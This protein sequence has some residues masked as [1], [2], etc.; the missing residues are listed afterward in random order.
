MGK[1]KY[2]PLIVLLL[3]AS[4]L[5]G[6]GASKDANMISSY[7]VQ[8]SGNT[9]LD[10]LPYNAIIV[11]HS[12]IDLQVSSIPSTVDDIME[13]AG[14]YG[15]YTTYAYIWYLDTEEH[16]TVIVSVPTFNYDPLYDRITRLGNLKDETIIGE[17]SSV[18]NRDGSKLEMSTI[19]VHLTEK[20]FLTSRPSKG[21]RPLNTLANAFEVTETI[22]RFLFDVFIWIVVIVGPFVLIGWGI[23]QAARRWQITIKKNNQ[24][25]D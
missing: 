3:L 7:P 16:A 6:C 21:W 22:F 25:N 14:K 4:I 5:A 24:D 15:G 8:S 17:L 10:S 20:A 23:K 13:L 2:T 12:Q 19:T 9:E 18:S 1:T 11:Y